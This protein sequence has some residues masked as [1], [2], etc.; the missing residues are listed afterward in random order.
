[1]HEQGREYPIP[2]TITD[3][4]FVTILEYKLILKRSPLLTMRFTPTPKFRT[5]QLSWIFKI[6]LANSLTRG[7]YH[8]LEIGYSQRYYDRVGGWPWFGLKNIFSIFTLRKEIL[9]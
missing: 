4:S 3:F 2:F 1:M 7:I 5:E 6:S 9:F 8:H